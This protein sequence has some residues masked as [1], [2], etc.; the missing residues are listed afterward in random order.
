MTMKISITERSQLLNGFVFE[1]HWILIDKG[2]YTSHG[3]PFRGSGSQVGKA[4]GTNTGT[5][6][7]PKSIDGYH[8]RYEPADLEAE[9]VICKRCGKKMKHRSTRIR[10]VKGS[11]GDI[12]CIVDAPRFACKCGCSRTMHPYFLA[13]RKKYSLVA[14]QEIVSEDAYGDRKGMSELAGYSNVYNSRRWA[15]RYLWGLLDEHQIEWPASLPKIDSIPSSREACHAFIRAF[16]EE[17]GNDWL[18]Q[19]VQVLHKADPVDLSPFRLFH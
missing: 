13:P 5:K 4:M 17:Y 10:E 7:A 14:I 2:F 16:F 1:L 12:C 11:A 8:Y 18:I 15:V 9:K 6:H 3:Y 19:I